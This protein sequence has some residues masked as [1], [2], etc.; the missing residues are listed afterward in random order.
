MTERKFDP[1]LSNIY[2]PRDS[3]NVLV[4]FEDGNLTEINL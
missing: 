2:K 4:K 3:L 1:L